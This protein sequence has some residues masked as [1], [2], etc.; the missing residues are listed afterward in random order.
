PG[1]GDP[2]D[3]R[4]PKIA[5][6]REITGELLATRQ[7]FFSVCLGHQVL[8]T[9]LGLPVRRRA[10]SNQGVLRVIDL[11]GAAEPVYF[12][13]AF[14][15]HSDSDAFET[16]VG[17]RPVAVARDQHTGEV[18][19]LRGDGFASLQFH[20]A[21]VMSRNGSRIVA[22]LVTELLTPAELSTQR[23]AWLGECSLN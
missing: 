21:S 2:R 19:G 22:R 10:V 5:R 9:V 13:N 12:Y 6:L 14:E 1:P 8:S 4:D 18:H 11:F 17:S 23:V 16:R 20:P 7:P 3:A 15:S